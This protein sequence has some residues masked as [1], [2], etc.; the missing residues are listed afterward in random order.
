MNE[1]I[2]LALDIKIEKPMKR[3]GSCRQQQPLR[4]F[5]ENR[6]NRDGR[7]ADCLLCQ[8]A[9][10]VRRTACGCA[11]TMPVRGWQNGQPGGLPR[12]RKW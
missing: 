3:C 2:Q 12:M 7:T 10:S 5:N 6:R 1:D 4:M 8:T 9:N 11:N